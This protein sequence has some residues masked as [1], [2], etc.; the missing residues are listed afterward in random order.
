MHLNYNHI[1]PVMKTILEI[2]DENL[3]KICSA[4]EVGNLRSGSYLAIELT[5]I[6]DLM[7]FDEGIFISEVIESSISQITAEMNSYDVQKQDFDALLLSLQSQINSILKCYKKEDKNELYLVLQN[8]RAISTKFQF[9]CR[10]N[11]KA[12]QKKFDPLD[13]LRR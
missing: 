1:V 13:I 4:L 9:N 12:S 11:C 6:S 10:R 7:G 8:L 2:F 3:S 5:T